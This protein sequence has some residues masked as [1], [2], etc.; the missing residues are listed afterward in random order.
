M[1]V[2]VPKCRRGCER[3]KHGVVV[4]CAACVDRFHRNLGELLE[5]RGHDD[6]AAWHRALGREMG[7][8]GSAGVL[9]GYAARRDVTTS[10]A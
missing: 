1:T 2:I 8:A 3:D 5:E 7:T 10:E 6:L 9:R 4:P